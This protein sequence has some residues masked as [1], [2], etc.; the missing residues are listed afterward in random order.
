MSLHDPLGRVTPRPVQSIPINVPDPRDLRPAPTTMEPMN[1]S[2]PALKSGTVR[3]GITLILITIWKPLVMLV[4]GVLLL[5][6]LQVDTATWIPYADDGAIS[7][8]EWFAIARDVLRALAM[9][10]TALIILSFMYP[11]AKAAS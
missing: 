9:S 10:L 4:G 8:A 2:Q 5:V 3:T 7:A 6:G 11:R 1:N